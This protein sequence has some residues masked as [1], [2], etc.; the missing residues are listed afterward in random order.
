[1]CEGYFKKLC[2]EAGLTEVEA[3]SAGVFAS[4]GEKASQTAVAALKRF[5]VDISGH[6]ARQLDKAMVDEAD[7][8]VAMGAGHRA[9]IG[10]IN[11]KALAKTH[12]LM[13]YADKPGTD[14]ADPFGGSQETYS[15]CFSEMKPALDNL[16]VEIFR[17]R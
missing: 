15:A 13:E 9:H 3:S 10:R 12:L 14:V 2:Q 8:I 11:P 7:L 17:K 16:F 1:M 5:G 6:R 4:A